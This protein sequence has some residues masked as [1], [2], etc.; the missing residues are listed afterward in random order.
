MFKQFWVI[1]NKEVKDAVRDHKALMSAF[2]LPVLMAVMTSAG[3]LLIIKSIDDAEHITLPVAGAEY[4]QP[5][6][7]WLEEQGIEVTLAPED[8]VAAVS[9]QSL[10][11]VLII[12]EQVSED[13][14]SAEPSTLWLVMDTSRQDLMSQ[15]RTIKSYIRQWSSQV[16]GLRLLA[17]GI[18]PQV[19]TPV[20]VQEVNVADS[21]KLAS[22]V[23]GS[24][25]L[26]VLMAMFA[27]SIG[28]AA[29]VTAGER[30]RRSL[31][32]LLINPVPRN[33]V[34]Y[35]KW[36][37]TML[38]ALVITVITLALQ[39]LVARLLPLSELDIRF[40]LGVTEISVM[41]LI[42][43]P[44]VFMGSAIQLFVAIFARS[45]KDAQTYMSLLVI[46]PMI[47]GVYV[48]MNPGDYEMW[49]VAIPLL[50]PQLLL[51]DLFGGELPS[52]EASVL[53]MVESI[54]LGLFV[55]RLTEWKLRREATIY[56]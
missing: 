54:V 14:R 37:T 40:D 21:Q 29:D 18:S 45:F 49:Q 44:V 27:G 35:G 30:E 46:V 32:P 28:L 41:L 33:V 9:D 15:A 53:V 50:G 6:V 3:V 36:A 39:L 51:V 31:E 38:F 23:L 56:G 11:F 4:A 42:I 19:A 25:P 20:L 24:M 17:Q 8:P 47:P 12:P 10:D 55:S 7:Q 26:V 2:F 1:F 48:L 16:G 34:I 43:V 5:L 22:R 13:L 52:I